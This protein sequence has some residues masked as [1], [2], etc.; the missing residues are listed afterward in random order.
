MIGDAPG[1]K[2]AAKSNN[3]LF[4]P[5]KPAHETESWERFYKEAFH[6]FI[7]GTYAGEYEESLIAEFGA[8]L[9]ATPPWE[10]KI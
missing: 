9:P 1:D 8:L 2:A 7:N 5:I 6:K 4:Y 10:N 3:A